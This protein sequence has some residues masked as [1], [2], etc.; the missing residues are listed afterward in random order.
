MDKL[1][2]KNMEFFAYHGV[3]NEERINGQNFEIDVDMIL[4]LAASAL[5]DNVRDTVDYSQVYL[6][7]KEFATQRRYNLI[8]TL[9]SRI[10][11]VVL[12][13]NPKI[14][15]VHVRVRKPQAPIIGKLAGPEVEIRRARN[16]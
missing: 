10:A 9:A 3:L 13:K 15:E 5:S 8:E 16:D 12:L 7:V 11:D 4:D 14:Q 2:L 1:F 6:D